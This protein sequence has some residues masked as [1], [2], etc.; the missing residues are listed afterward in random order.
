MSSHSTVERENRENT[1]HSDLCTL[2]LALI[3][4]CFVLLLQETRLLSSYLGP[5]L[6]IFSVMLS[7]L[8]LQ[9]LLSSVYGHH[10]SNILTFTLLK[11]SFL[12]STFH[13]SYYTFAPQSGANNWFKNI[14]ELS[15]WTFKSKRQLYSTHRA[16]L[17]NYFMWNMN[18][19]TSTV[20][21]FINRWKPIHL[22]GDLERESKTTDI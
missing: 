11:K 21:L 15:T 20:D 5:S 17:M 8:D 2:T 19:F 1:E 22:I 3:L 16:H 18:Y 12:H 14:S 10:H 9:I 6:S 7:L 4:F 13:S